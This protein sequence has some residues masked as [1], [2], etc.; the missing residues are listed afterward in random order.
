VFPNLFQV[1]RIL[2]VELAYQ[3]D[4]AFVAVGRC[5]LK[6]WRRFHQPSAKVLVD[7]ANLALH[8]KTWFGWPKLVKLVT[9]NQV[10]T[11]LVFCLSCPTYHARLTSCQ[12]MCLIGSLVLSGFLL[13]CFTAL[14]LF[15]FTA[16]LL[17]CF[18]AFTGFTAFNAFDAFNAHLNQLA[19]LENSSGIQKLP[20]V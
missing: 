18:N 19:K 2:L 17:Y 14:L 1:T 9:N 11:L 7:L 16:L 5:E 13:H 20:T 6:H 15:C 12:T 3:L 10:D 4:Q 8:L